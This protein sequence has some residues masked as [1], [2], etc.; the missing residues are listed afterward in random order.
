V[1]LYAKHERKPKELAIE[2]QNFDLTKLI[3]AAS[4]EVARKFFLR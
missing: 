2:L 3:M 4:R 1:P